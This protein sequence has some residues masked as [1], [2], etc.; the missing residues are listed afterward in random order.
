MRQKLKQVEHLCTTMHFSLF[1]TFKASVRGVKGESGYL[2]HLTE[3]LDLNSDLEDL[4]IHTVLHFTNFFLL[5]SLEIVYTLYI[6]QFF[7]VGHRLNTLIIT[8]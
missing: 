8:W 4:E 5:S 1:Y 2:L 7:S 6:F 3:N